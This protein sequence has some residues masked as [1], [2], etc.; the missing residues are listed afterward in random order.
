MTSAQ[1]PQSEIAELRQYAALWGANAAKALEWARDR[2]G[3]HPISKI[4]DAEHAARMAWRAA[5]DSLTLEE[6]ANE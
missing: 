6:M 3:G 2:F 5:L 4:H 1:W